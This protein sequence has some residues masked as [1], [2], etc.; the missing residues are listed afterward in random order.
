VLAGPGEAEQAA[1]RLVALHR[2]LL[3][4]QD[5]P[6]THMI[7]KFE[8]FIVA[9]A[10]RMTD[11]GLGAI[12]E[13]WRD[14]KVIISSF[15]LF[16]DKIIDGYLIGVRPE[17]AQ[18]YQWSSLKIYDLLNTAR[19]RNSAHVCLAHAGAPYKQRWPHEDVPSYRIVLGRGAVSWRLYLMTLFLLERGKKAMPKRA[20]RIIKRI[21]L[22]ILIKNPAHWLRHIRRR[23]RRLG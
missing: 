10:R 4:G 17:A 19:S 21:A 9:A 2:E 20:K 18:R 6:W 14:G 11:R 13:S 5:I 8:S 7:P 15:E 22:A 3:Q 1:G 12:S 16:G 23:I